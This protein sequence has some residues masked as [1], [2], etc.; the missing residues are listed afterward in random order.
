MVLEDGIVLQLG[1]ESFRK[2]MAPKMDGTWNL[3]GQ[4]ANRALDFFVLFSSVSSLVGNPGQANYVAA[5][6]FL[7]AFAYYRR[8]LGLPATTINLGHVAETGYVSRQQALSELLTQR[9]I[10]GFS[11]KQAMAA[12]GRML[13]KNPIQ[14][15]VM[16]MDWHKVAKSTS[17]AEVPQRL[18]SLIG[19][20]G[21]E[22]QGGEEGSRLREALLHAT[23]EE[24]EA[25]VQTY[26]REQ[27]AR[28]LGASAAKLDIDRPLNELGL[29]SLMSVELKNRV[30]GDVALSLP[31]SALMQSPTINSLSTAMLNQL[32]TLASTPST[33]PLTHRETAEHLLTRV[34]QLS[35]Q[36]VDVL[37]RE[38]VGEEVNETVQTEE[39]V[40]G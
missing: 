28:V 32:T 7:D 9:G 24:R 26:I 38:M 34:D 25:I 29:D 36:E 5:N 23:R 3:H 11:S 6:T 21:I 40:I 17:R 15:G 19:A 2:V 13:Q 14:M 39:E 22:P 33:P 16:R 30:E 37:L 20:S 8:S 31:M 10:L 1:P 27:V 35:E 12:L 4:T 18:S